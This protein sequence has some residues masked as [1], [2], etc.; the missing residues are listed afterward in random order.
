MPRKKNDATYPK[1]LGYLYPYNK[2]M[3]FFE[4]F[5]LESRRFRKRSVDFVELLIAPPSV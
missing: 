1:G 5:G 4:T 3:Y 2:E